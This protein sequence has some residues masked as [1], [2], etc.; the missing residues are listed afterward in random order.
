MLIPVAKLSPTEAASFLLQGLTAYHLLQTFGNLKPGETVLV[1]AAAGGVGSIA[2]QL[3]RAFGAG[4]VLATAGTPQKLEVA[5]SLGADAAFDYTQENW[6]REVIDYLD[7]KGVNLILEAVGGKVFS[8]SL[9]CLAPLG[10]I[11][12]YGTSSHEKTQLEHTQLMKLCQTMIGFDLNFVARSSKMIALGSI[13]L[14]K[15]LGLGNLKLLQNHVL[16]LEE[17]AEAHR[18]L[19]QRLTTGKVVL[20]L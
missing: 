12:V 16:P 7:G 6:E 3:A 1:R 4:K 14:L 5:R 2:V 9:K 17:A 10:R 18:L 15:Q 13:E 11:M 8:D 20:T 19:E